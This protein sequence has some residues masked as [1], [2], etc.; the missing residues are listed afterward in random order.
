MS[1]PGTVRPVEDRRLLAIAMML[2]AFACFTLVDTSAK[3][4]ILSGMD[5]MQVVFVRYAVHALLALAI[6]SSLEGRDLFRTGA[7]M[8]IG[9]RAFCLLLSTIFNFTAVQY[10]PLTLTATI[11]FT[12]PLWVC[13]LSIPLLGE[14]VGARRWA[15]ILMGF[16]G[17]LIATRPWGAEIHWAV[18][19]SIGAAVAA[20]LY[21]ILTRKLAGVESTSTQQFYGAALSALVMAPP[22]LAD[23]SWPVAAPDWGFF[24]V[25]GIAGLVGHQ[26]L[27]VAHRYAE[28]STLAPFV[29][30]QMIY[31]TAASWFVFGNPPDAW[32]FAGATVVLASGLYIWLRERQIARGQTMAQVIRT[33]RS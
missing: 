26:L 3:W 32:I 12:V 16:S 24:V 30:V 11:F 13:M 5:N 7:P 27:T 21:G 33:P 18:F 19:F 2:G 10:L 8:L 25:I 20:S 1:A 28:A 14:K 29:Y 15:A 22:A 6:F 9:L 31:M 23:W 4:L 17:V